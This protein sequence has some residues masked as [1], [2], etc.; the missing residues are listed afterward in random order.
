MSS[1][2]LL[3]LQQQTF[4]LLVAPAKAGTKL[5]ELCSLLASAVEGRVCLENISGP[6]E[7]VMGQKV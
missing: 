4:D 3:P 5:N 2:C 1:L 7:Y 6:V